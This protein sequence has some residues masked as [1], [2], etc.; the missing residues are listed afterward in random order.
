[1]SESDLP[2]VSAGDLSVTT[3]HEGDTITV[4]CIGTADLRVGDAL[5]RVLSRVHKTALERKAARVD[6]DFRALEFMN[7]AC[8]KSFVTWISDVRELDAEKKYAIRFWSKPELLWQRRSLHALR[9]FA[10]DVI[11]IES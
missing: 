5:D 10:T 11:T 2:S 6:I 3:R 8:F 4:F 9:C 7:S 1:M